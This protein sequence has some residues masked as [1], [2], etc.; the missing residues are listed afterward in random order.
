MGATR[1]LYNNHKPNR[2]TGT[3]WRSVMVD[4]ITHPWVPV[5]THNT[6]VL[7]KEAVGD[8][9][10]MFHSEPDAVHTDVSPL[11]DAHMVTEPFEFHITV[12]TIPEF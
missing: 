4:I 1:P 8:Q 6:R 3:N 11:R 5:D 7:D 10:S 9:Q 2:R 12:L